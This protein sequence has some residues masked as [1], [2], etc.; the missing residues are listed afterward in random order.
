VPRGGHGEDAVEV[1]D[2]FG[3]A[4]G[5]GISPRWLATV[6]HWWRWEVATVELRCTMGC[7]RKSTEWGCQR[8]PPNREAGEGGGV[9][10]S[11]NL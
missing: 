4:A 2:P 6:G 9:L 5:R 3:G 8:A 11:G 7:G 10:T 1:G